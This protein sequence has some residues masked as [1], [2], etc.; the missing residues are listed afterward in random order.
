MHLNAVN[1][2]T[3]HILKTPEVLCNVAMSDLLDDQRKFQRIPVQRPRA[4]KDRSDQA[5]DQATCIRI[6][7]N[8]V[9]E[10]RE[11][12]DEEPGKNPLVI[13]RDFVTGLLR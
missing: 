1:I 2:R 6:P 3:F 8:V 13:V 4:A 5:F 9:R 7:K 10:A 12:V 11:Q